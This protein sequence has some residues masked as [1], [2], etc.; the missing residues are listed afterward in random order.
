MKHKIIFE[1]IKSNEYSQQIT[2][3]GTP[4]IVI[5]KKSLD[6]T[7]G[8]DHSVSKKQKNKDAK[9]KGKVRL[10]KLFKVVFVFKRLNQKH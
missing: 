1:D 9:I 10:Y 3:S 2:W 4:F 7:H 8:K 5:G 6:C